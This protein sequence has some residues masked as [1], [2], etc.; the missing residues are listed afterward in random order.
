MTVLALVAALCFVIGLIVV[1]TSGEF[2]L[3]AGGWVAAGLVLL[4]V[5]AALGDAYI[6]RRLGRQ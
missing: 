1:E 4:A 2:L 3:S 5:H 6:T